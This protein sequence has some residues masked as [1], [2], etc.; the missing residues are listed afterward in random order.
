[1]NTYQLSFSAGI[2]TRTVVCAIYAIGDQSAI[3][4]AEAEI[5][6]SKFAAIAD[7]ASLWTSTDKLV[8]S[9]NISRPT[10]ATS[11]KVK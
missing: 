9:W 4:Q 10:V 1:M 11:R 3:M 5:E 8:A 2:G 7:S 6:N